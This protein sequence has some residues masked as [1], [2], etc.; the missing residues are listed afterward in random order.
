MQKQKIGKVILIFSTQRSGSTMV[1]S[2]FTETNILGKPSEYFTEKILPG[3]K[4]ENCTLSVEEIAEEIE[5]ILQRAKTSNGVLAIKIMSDYVLEIAKAIEKIGVG[6]QPNDFQGQERKAYLQKLFINFFND[7][8]V[9]GQFVAFRVYRKNKVK[10]AVS[11]FVAAR[12]GLYHVWKNDEGQLMNHYDRPSEKATP[13]SLD[14]DK[15]YSHEK[16]SEIIHSLYLQERQLDILLENF[17]I[18]PTNLIYESIIES[19]KYLQ[20]I[21]ESIDYL[22]DSRLVEEVPRKTVK[23]TSPLNKELIKRFDE[24]RGYVGNIE[25]ILSEPDNFIKHISSPP[26]KTVINKT[27]F[28]NREL[29]DL[30]ITDPERK[31]SRDLLIIDGVIVSRS[32]IS[33]VFII[34]P[35]SNQEYNADINLN[36][37]YFGSIYWG[38][39]GSNK[40]RFRCL[41]PL[42][43]QTIQNSTPTNLILNYQTQES[44]LVKLAELD[45]S[46][47][48]GK[49]HQTL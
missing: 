46:R 4:F 40:S 15:H 22:N 43:S 32:V 7:L 13:F 35:I 17:K 42:D 6:T 11:S 29:I 45:I 14:I 31:D 28:F 1:T 33:K 8:D 39:E 47:F 10:Q 16:I 48:V 5:S 41:V 38:V 23:T 49:I 3:S 20:P 44:S 2:D 21:I 9:D 24:D 37:E 36:S 27:C 12:T 18:K 30:E 25:C 19:T 34:D 26:E